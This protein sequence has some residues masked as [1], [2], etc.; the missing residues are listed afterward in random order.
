MKR[1]ILIGII[2]LGFLLR[3]IALTNHPAGF[4]PDEAS[5]GYDAYSLLKTGKDQWGKPFPLVFKSFGD[6][7][8][9]VYTYLAMPS[10]AIF[11][12]KEFSVRLPNAILGSLAIIVVYLLVKELFKDERIALFASLLFAISP[13]HVMLSRGAFEANLTTFFLPL[14]I[15][16]FLKS[17][18]DKKILFLSFLVFFINIFTYHTA[19]ILTPIV[20][21]SLVLL[22]RKELKE[23]KLINITVLL[24][25]IILIISVV[26]FLIGGSRLASSSIFSSVNTDIQFYSVKVGEP[27]LFAKLFSNKLLIVGQTA[28][29][30][31]L[32]YFSPQF[33]FTNGP[34]EGTYG[35]VPGTG[36]LYLIEVV[37]LLGF[38]IK[39]I[40]KGFIKTDI[41]LLIWIFISP[42][43][44]SLT[45]GPGLAAN[46]ATFMM[47]AIQIISG[48]G[49]IYLYDLIGKNFKKKA[50]IATSIIFSIL[51]IFFINDYFV[52]QPALYAK[53]MGYGAK[54]IF[55]FLGTQQSMVFSDNSGGFIIS[56]KIS[57]PQ[58]YA[59]FYNKID[60]LE[61]QRASKNWNFEEK[62]YI[63][64]D[65][66]PE[67]KLDKYLFSD[68]PNIPMWYGVFPPEI[69]PTQ[70]CPSQILK[71]V[72][73]PN[74]QEIYD[75]RLNSIS[76]SHGPC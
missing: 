66:I 49:A 13:W 9:P 38:A 39:I 12:L 2:V 10:V 54:E 29:R 30:N 15:L 27:I 11:G 22:F 59:A 20:I 19:R 24:S 40:K 17:F 18:K 14:G 70:I 34:N 31:Y 16:L 67:Y 69:I 74:G 3:T 26:G 41:F 53:D 75:I 25:S 50:I 46:R 57:E 37:F 55:E 68:N 48:V 73:L 47:P 7:K 71:K 62:G 21:F 58:I 76:K 64:V 36:V 43:P 63:W 60:P 42:I 23:M 65:E 33:L 45:S 52:K 8:L 4:T 72:Y 28:F 5:F 44:A 56:K 6:D 61:Y 1:W 32:S 35:M 51:F